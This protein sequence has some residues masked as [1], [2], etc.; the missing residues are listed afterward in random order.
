[1]YIIFDKPVRSIFE[2]SRPTFAD[3][4]MDFGETE[5][6]VADW[7]YLFREWENLWACVKAIM[8]F[9]VP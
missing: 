8:K 7:I 1:V 3:N 5:W 2:R 6:D 9:W 4:K